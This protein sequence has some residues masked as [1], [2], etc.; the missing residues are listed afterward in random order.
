MIMKSKLRKLPGWIGTGIITLL[1]GLWMVWGIGEAFYEGW[2]VPET[3][4]FLYL[5]IAVAAMLFS[6]LAILLPFIGGGILVL[7]GL[8]FA[9]WWIVPGLT[10]GLYTLSTVAGRLF[11]SAGFTIVGAMFILDGSLNPRKKGEHKPWVLKNIRLLTAIGIPLIVGA[12]VAGFNLPTVLTRVDDGDRSARLIEGEG[13]AL[14]WAPEG[15]GWNWKQDFGGYPSWDA[16]ALYGVEPLGL[17]ADKLE[18][19]HADE[20]NMAETGLCAYLDESGENLM[21]EPQYIWRM[22]TAE[23]IAG[24]LSLHNENAGCTWSGE[25]GKLSCTLNPDKETPLWA[26]DGQPVYYW[27]ADAYDDEEAYF[28][29][30]TGYV[31]FQPKS[32]GNPRHGY[33]CVKEP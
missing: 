27:A 23:E 14:V 9:I 18:G 26:P 30:Y 16:L 11:L 24:S 33:R 29:S 3:P 8:A 17:D 22:P 25:T 1:N 5:S 4:W 31:N 6:V 7:A 28:V 32:W 13:V 15:P 19:Q 12:V 20:T 21:D 10:Q 2:G